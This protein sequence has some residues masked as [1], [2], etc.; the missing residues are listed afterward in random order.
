MKQQSFWSGFAVGAA[1]GTLAGVGGVLAWKGLSA[2][3]DR[4]IVRLEKSINVGRPAPTVFS[5][6]MS[7]ERL[8]QMIDFIRKV[9]RFGNRSRWSVNIDGKDF[10]W[11]AQITQLVPGQSIGWKSVN[12]PQHTGRITFSPLGQQTLVHVTMNYAPPLAG[13]L[14]P[15]DQ[16]L[17]DWIERGLRQF[18][19]AVEAMPEAVNL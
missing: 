13:A 5:T 7:F 12:G 16:H 11:D 10:Q 18:K 9:E 2:S 1:V 6:W 15:I 8:P 17:E 14:L 3:T 4:R 19:S